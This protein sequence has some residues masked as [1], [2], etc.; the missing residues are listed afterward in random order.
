[1]LGRVRARPHLVQHPRLPLLAQLHHADAPNVLQEEQRVGPQAAERVHQSVNI[2]GC[3]RHLLHLAPRRR[4]GPA[5]GEAEQRAGERPLQIA[6]K[7]HIGPK[8]IR[9][10]RHDVA[11]RE[12]NTQTRLLRGGAGEVARVRVKEDQV[13]PTHE[14]GQ[15]REVVDSVEAQPEL[16][17]LAK[18]IELASLPDAREVDE[19]LR[20]ED[21]VV[22]E[23]DRGA[24]PAG[25]GRSEERGGTKGA[26]AHHHRH[27]ARARVV[28][29]LHQ[30]VEDLR[31]V[32]VQL[33][34]APK[35]SG[36]RLALPKGLRF[37]QPGPEAIRTAH[38]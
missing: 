10:L 20:A 12:A 15:I 21:G 36:Q 23:V 3:V 8:L 33:K 29:I 28:S 25:Q 38:Q 6:A 34:N 2:V 32:R 19:V 17:R 24:L 4:L 9:E 30:L 14:A 31:P 22:V 35:P 11:A 26:T 27:L 37:L 13:F 1:M 16:T 18:A 7:H 5:Q